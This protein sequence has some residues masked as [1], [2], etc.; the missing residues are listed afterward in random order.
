MKELPKRITVIFEP[1]A[2]CNLRCLHC[3]H[4]DTDYLPDIM[5]IEVLDKFLSVLKPHYNSV[6]IIWHGGE[7][8]LAGYDYFVKAYDR[9]ADFARETG[10]KF[11]FYIQ[12][13]G[14]LLDETYA[15]LF[16][17]TDTNISISYDGPY[18]DVLRQETDKV[19]E[20][21]DMLQHRGIDLRC[22]ST[23]SASTVHHLVKI[24]EFFKS[25]QLPVKFNPIFP[26]GAALSH[27]ELAISKEDWTDNFIDFFDYWLDDKACNIRVASCMDII[28]RFFGVRNGCLNNRCLF[29]YLAFDARGNFY[30][31]GRLIKEDY[32]LANVNEIDDLREVFLSPTYLSI[33]DANKARVAKCHA[34]KWYDKCHSGC[35]ATASLFGNMAN[36]NDFECYFNKRFFDHLADICAQG[37]P[38]SN[39]Y[40]KQL[41]CKIL[42]RDKI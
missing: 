9:F 11:D 14:T 31:C 25:K 34:C 42:N 10:V 1:T 21:I 33:L 24:Y 27:K 41:F 15:N 40:A 17:T 22:L 38:I 37:K 36:R 4:A 3:Y 35:N 19:E 20:T 39:P 18:N 12:T 2:A 16:E 6:N 23:V 30:P 29:R 32:R 8:L 7:P 26:D 5:P 28:H 13:N